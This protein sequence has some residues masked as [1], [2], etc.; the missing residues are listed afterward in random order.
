[1]DKITQIERIKIKLRLAKTTDAFLE[2]FGASSHRYVLDKPLKKERVEEFE[3]EYNISLPEG[4]KTFLTEIGNGGREYGNSVVGNSGAGPYYGIFKLG[5]HFHFVDAGSKTYLQFDPYFNNTIT[6]EVW[7][8]MYADMP[9]N[10]SD[11]EYD[12]CLARA[13][14][15]ILNIAY[16]GCEGYVGMIINGPDKGRV[17]YTYDDM[18]YPIH[19]AGEFKFLDWYENWLD[20]IIS[21]KEIF[22]KGMI[23]QGEE[24]CLNRFLSDK[25]PYW[26]FV[27]LAYLRSFETL[28]E[29][30]VKTLWEAYRKDQ[31][32]GVKLY[33]LNL[34]TKFD[35][36]N[37]KEEIAAL[38]KNP[39]EF[40]RNLHLYA[41]EKTT[42]WKK[43][44]ERIKRK[45]SRK[46]EIQDYIK[47]VTEKDGKRDS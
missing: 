35:Y 31:D 13:Y 12:K 32:E 17:L 10:I 14:G 43:E 30:S 9:D 47:Y 42:D 1:M 39:A 7:D 37:A 28:S 45:H 16:C 15:G 23:N 11:E 5:H 33:L 46:E 34:L 27:S 29:V 3:K 40:L 8:K 26:Q 18:E 6:A 4:Y 44:I 38:R 41:P 24:S 36:S 19:F 25:E 22:M 20:N 21:G 2:V